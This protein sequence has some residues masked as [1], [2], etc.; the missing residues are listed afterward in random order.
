MLLSQGRI[1]LWPQ[2]YQRLQQSALKIG[3]PCPQ[4]DWLAEQLQPYIELPQDLVLK[5]ILTRGSGGRGLQLPEPL[6][7]T[8]YLIKYP[9]KN[10]I[11][12]SVKAYFSE[13]TL[14][15][16]PNLAGLKHLNRLDYVLATQALK[17]Q[18]DYD[19][20]LLIDSEGHVIEAIVHNLFFVADDVICTPDLSQA[21]VDGVMRQLIVKSLIERGKNVKI[22]HFTRQ[23]LLSA[24]ECFVCNSVHGIRALVQLEQ[25]TYPIGPVTERLQNTFNAALD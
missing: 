7:P 9:F 19:E 12:Q 8:I 18:Q 23:D 14:P 11:N 17:Q 10:D 6:V 22:G 16:N 2:H 5:L 25:Q 24:S 3:I 21:G 13:I 20:A 4:Q 1:R 15:K